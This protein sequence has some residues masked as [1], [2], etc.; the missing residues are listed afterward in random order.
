MIEVIVE[1]HF[2]PGRMEDTARLLAEM[3]RRVM[4]QNG[5]VSGEI[6]QSADNPSVWIDTSTWTYSD[7]WKKWETTPEHNE[8]QC[9]VE[10]LL[11]AP[12]KVF[13]CN[14]IR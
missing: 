1:R 14:V 9:E 12:E 2:Q 10:R 5:Y 13:I 11:A 4:R 8:I 7:Q 6:L 3:R